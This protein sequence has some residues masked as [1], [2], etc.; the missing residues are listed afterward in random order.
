MD[1]QSQTVPRVDGHI[2]G[3]NIN[4]AEMFEVL[5]PARPAPCGFTFDEH[6]RLIGKYGLGEPSEKD[7]THTVFKPDTTHSVLQAALEKISDAGLK[8]ALAQTLKESQ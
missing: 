5:C 1:W 6:G 2:Y 8:A 7:M 4:G 3:D